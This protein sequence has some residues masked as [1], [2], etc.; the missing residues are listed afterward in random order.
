MDQNDVNDIRNCIPFIHLLQVRL[1]LYGEKRFGQEGEEQPVRTEADK[2]YYDPR[3]W[4]FFSDEQNVRTAIKII[5]NRKSQSPTT[6]MSSQSPTTT[7]EAALPE[8]FWKIISFFFTEVSDSCVIKKG[9][10][11]EG[12]NVKP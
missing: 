7:S 8:N 2:L 5:L 11:E 9:E 10:S 1:I 4:D 6:I 12:C 3:A